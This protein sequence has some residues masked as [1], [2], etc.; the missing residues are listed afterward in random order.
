MFFQIELEITRK[1]TCL[2]VTVFSSSV[3]CL[4]VLLSLWFYQS[5]TTLL[6][7]LRISCEC[8]RVS[9]FNLSQIPKLDNWCIFHRIS[10]SS[11]LLIPRE[12]VM[13]MSS[14]GNGVPGANCA[15]LICAHASSL[16]CKSPNLSRRPL[17]W[18]LVTHILTCLLGTSWQCN[19]LAFLLGFLCRLA[20]CTPH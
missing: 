14:N 10:S 18:L 7:T 6:R 5:V 15:Q 1:C 8:F 11:S 9:K 19:V 3:V 12:M 4:L 13:G 17:Y 16:A 2:N 20:K